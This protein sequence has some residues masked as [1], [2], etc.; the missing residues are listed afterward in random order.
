MKLLILTKRFGQTYTGATKSTYK[1]AEHW[2]NKG[3]EVCV[4][5]KEVDDSELVKFNVE[6]WTSKID[7]MK[8][9]SQHNNPNVIGYSDDHLGFFLGLK[10]IRY[11]HTYHGNW[12]DAMYLNG[13]MGFIKGMWFIP[14]YAGTFLLADNVVN[15]SRYMYRFTRR[16]SK[17]L[18]ILRNGLDRPV[19]KMFGQ[20]TIRNNKF[21]IVMVGGVDYRKFGKLHD[22]VDQLKEKNVDFEIDVFGSIH[23]KD[24]VKSFDQELNVIFKGFSHNLNYG[25]YDAFLS[26]SATENLSI[27]TVEAIANNVPVFAFNVG[28]TN[29]VVKMPNNGMLAKRGDVGELAKYIENFVNGKTIF[30]IDTDSVIQEFSWETTGNAYLELFRRELG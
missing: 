29:E 11:T 9:I 28:G 12:P 3:H 1:L 20:T 6:K 10:G 16:F 13:A 26:T 18:L 2:S 30:N 19:K 15:V 8:K 5:A 14:Q 25:Q 7:L 24:I 21:K 4:L 23:D 22:L 27:A 17:K